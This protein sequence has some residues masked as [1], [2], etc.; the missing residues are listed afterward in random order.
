MKAK[1]LSEKMDT[2]EGL[3]IEVHGKYFNCKANWENK[4]E[5]LDFLNWWLA[6]ER[7]EKNELERKLK[8]TRRIIKLLK[9]WIEAEKGEEE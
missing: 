7:L 2:K 6:G 8:V 1:P 5:R 3:I 4:E 9:R